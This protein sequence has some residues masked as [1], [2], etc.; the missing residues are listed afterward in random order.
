MVRQG[1]CGKR[2]LKQKI[3]VKKIQKPPKKKGGFF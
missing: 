2:K 3:K 1:G